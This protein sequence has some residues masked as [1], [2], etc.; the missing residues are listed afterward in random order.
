MSEETE[1]IPT[2][3]LP[4]QGRLRRKDLL[5]LKLASANKKLK[6]RVEFLEKRIERIQRP[7]LH[8]RVWAFIKKLFRVE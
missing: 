6:A 7:A 1:D 2:R 4:R 3:K 8:K 5:I